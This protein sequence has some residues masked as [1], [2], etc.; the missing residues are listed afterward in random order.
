[1]LIQKHNT[2]LHS[3]NIIEEGPKHTEHYPSN[4]PNISKE[5]QDTRRTPNQIW[6]L[7]LHLELSDYVHPTLLDP[8]EG[9]CY[10]GSEKMITL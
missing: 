9:L 7:K 2:Y 8:V 10:F 5:I 1:M 3:S 6:L 4:K